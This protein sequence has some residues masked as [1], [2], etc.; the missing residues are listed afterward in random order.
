MFGNYV[1][2]FGAAA[3]CAANEAKLIG[4]GAVGRLLQGPSVKAATELEGIGAALAA[5]SKTPAAAMATPPQQS[6]LQQRV[7]MWLDKSHQQLS[8]LAEAP[9]GSL[10]WLEGVPEPQWAAFI[11][12]QPA[13]GEAAAE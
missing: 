13:A 10:G 2:G 1:G 11:V 3:T 5:L 12:V 9:A 6:S 7:A 8:K 4:R